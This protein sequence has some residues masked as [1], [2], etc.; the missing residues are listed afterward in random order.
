[1]RRG[2][3]PAGPA[4]HLRESPASL[5]GTGQGAEPARCPQHP[6]SNARGTAKRCQDRFVGG[7]RLPTAK[8]GFAFKAIRLQN[9]GSSQ[10]ATHPPGSQLPS[11]SLGGESLDVS[12]GG[13]EGGQRPGHSQVTTT[14]LAT[15]VSP[16]QRES[17]PHG[18]PLPAL[19][20]GVLTA[21]QMRC[22]VQVMRELLSSPRTNVCTWERC[23]R[24]HPEASISARRGLSISVRTGVCLLLPGVLGSSPPARCSLRSPGKWG[25][26]EDC[27]HGLH[28]P[29][30]RG[31]GGEG[32][33]ACC[34]PLRRRSSFPEGPG[35][36]EV[37]GRRLDRGREL[38]QRLTSAGSTG[39]GDRHHGSAV[40]RHAA[41][42]TSRQEGR[43]VCSLPRAERSWPAASGNPAGEVPP[44]PFV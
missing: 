44:D 4:C 16:V 5:T 25:A 10:G 28:C 43:P 36:R 13:P 17:A 14:E 15:S 33:R 18:P 7:H 3:T 37:A 35:L 22:A 40:T 39:P 41:L 20:P 32:S 27:S 31:R 19:F 11:P 26:G 2:W 30:K 34:W 21:S 38:Q 23:P 42:L 29:P 24:A 9:P 12:Q 6:R 8:A 1:M